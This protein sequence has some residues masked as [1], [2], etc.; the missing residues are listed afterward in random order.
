MELKTFD[1][2]PQ[3]KKAGEEAEE[4]LRALSTS[5]GNGS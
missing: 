5:A 1:T 4:D 2:L 3:E